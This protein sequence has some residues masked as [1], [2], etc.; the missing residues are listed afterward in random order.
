KEIKCPSCG[1]TTLARSTSN[2]CPDKKAK[3]PVCNSDERVETFVI[4][5]SLPNVCN[6]RQLVQ[7]IKGLADYTTKILF[8]SSLFAN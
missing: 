6:N 4:K 5:T 7:H 3:I 1:L 2:L 8:V